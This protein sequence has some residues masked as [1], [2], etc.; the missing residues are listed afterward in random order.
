MNAA[1]ASVNSSPV[2]E[3]A[4]V[5]SAEEITALVRACFGFLGSTALLVLCMIGLAAR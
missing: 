5:A 4:G 1:H 3:K 2:A